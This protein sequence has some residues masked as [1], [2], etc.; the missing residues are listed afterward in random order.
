[1]DGHSKKY[2]KKNK[3]EKKKKNSS[4][5]F[6]CKIFIIKVKI[7]SQ[8]FNK[9]FFQGSESEVE[10]VEKEF[11]ED[12]DVQVKKR[13]EWMSLEMDLSS[14]AHKKESKDKKDARKREA[15]PEKV[16]QCIIFS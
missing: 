2:K 10:W 13:D 3:K 15:K 4:V 7:V 6:T 16:Y 12:Q 1:M 9:L 8:F 11:K 14:L 5:K